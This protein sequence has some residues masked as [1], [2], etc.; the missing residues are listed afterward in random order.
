[1]TLTKFAFNSKSIRIELERCEGIEVPTIDGVIY[2]RAFTTSV[3]PG[4]SSAHQ[5]C[6]NCFP[7]F[8]WLAHS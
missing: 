1:V 6:Q 8:M 4:N 2:S 7:S 3:M 5:K